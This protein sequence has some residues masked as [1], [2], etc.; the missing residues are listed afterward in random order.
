MP[1]PSAS[2]PRSITHIVRSQRAVPGGLT[3]PIQ[4]FKHGSR[5]TPAESRSQ[6]PTHPSSGACIMYSSRLVVQNSPSP[7]TPISQASLA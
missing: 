5:D 4:G 1:M 7:K 2:L 6:Q 3:R